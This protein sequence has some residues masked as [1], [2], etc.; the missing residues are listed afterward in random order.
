MFNKKLNKKSFNLANTEIRASTRH[1][2][3]S[4]SEHD[5]IRWNTSI[6]EI[7]TFLHNLWNFRKNISAVKIYFP[8]HSS[9]DLAFA[10]LL[11][12]LRLQICHVCPAVPKLFPALSLFRYSPG[13]RRRVHLHK[14][15]DTNDHKNCSMRLTS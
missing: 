2:F 10:F 1:H 5:T 4:A 8:G 13:F 12:F 9:A 11:S 3:C 15:E 14:K 6:Q 7:Q